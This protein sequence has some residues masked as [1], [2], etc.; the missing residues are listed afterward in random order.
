MSR[1]KPVR[2][3]EEVRRRLEELRRELG[4]SSIGDVLQLL[5][6]DSLGGLVAAVL[7]ARSDV[8]SLVSELRRL[9]DNLGRLASLLERLAG[10]LVEES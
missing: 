2:I 6:G 5:V 10:R 3:P 1:S 8:K 7:D 9:N 4:L